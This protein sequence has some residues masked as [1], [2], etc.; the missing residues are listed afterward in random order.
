M[1]RV[2]FLPLLWSLCVLG[3]CSYTTLP[4][5]E[6]RTIAHIHVHDYVRASQD[7]EIRRPADI[8]RVVR[9][10]DAERTGYVPADG[11]AKLGTVLRID[12]FD[13][14]NT[15][16]LSVQTGPTGAYIAPPPGGALYLKGNVPVFPLT[17]GTY[18]GYAPLHDAIMAA[19]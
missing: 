13:R 15:I 2:F 12:F 4:N 16:V 5:V 11:T 19:R 10:Y 7:R 3:G 18:H 6:P 9:A 14:Q 1:R 17:Y 8:A